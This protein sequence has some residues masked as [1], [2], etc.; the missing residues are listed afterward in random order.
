[1]RCAGDFNEL[2][3]DGEDEKSRCE[4]MNWLCK[5][6]TEWLQKIKSNSRLNGDN[7]IKK[8]PFVQKL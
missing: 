2:E 3:I 6:P 8:Y 4:D 5:V 1:M 7:Y